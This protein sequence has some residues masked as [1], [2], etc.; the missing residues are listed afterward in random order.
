MWTFVIRSCNSPRSFAFEDFLGDGFLLGSARFGNL[1]VRRWSTC[2]L[3]EKIKRY[4]LSDLKY[5]HTVNL[6]DKRSEFAIS[7]FSFF[8]FKA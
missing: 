4:Y 1:I 3:T 5:H 6:K 8:F 2:S 7:F